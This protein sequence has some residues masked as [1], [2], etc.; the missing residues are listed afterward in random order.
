MEGIYSKMSMIAN[1]KV[2]NDVFLRDNI[3]E[4]IHDCK[5]SWEKTV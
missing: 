3:V 4:D 2:Q 5:I 1:D